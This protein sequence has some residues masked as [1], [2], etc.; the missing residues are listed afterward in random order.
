QKPHC[1]ASC[2]TKARWTGCSLPSAASP[3]MV[4]TSLPATSAIWTWHERTASPSTRTVQAP[5]WLSPQPYLVPVSSSSVR[6][7]HRSVA[8]P[9]A[10]SRTG[11]L[12]TLKRTSS[13]MAASVQRVLEARLGRTGAERSSA[14]LEEDVGLGVGE[15]RRRAGRP[16]P[17][18]A[19]VAPGGQRA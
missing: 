1:M 15:R 5:Q 10:G 3:S 13:A 12:F 17:A 16:G 18:V 7:A 2:S 6:N 9:A 4:V 19:V 11:L 14:A 8:P